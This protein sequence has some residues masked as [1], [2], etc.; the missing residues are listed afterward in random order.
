M[1]AS[2]DAALAGAAGALGADGDEWIA[3]IH[4]ED[5]I[6]S[7]VP[8]AEALLARDCAARWVRSLRVLPRWLRT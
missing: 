7:E 4:G 3:E 5:G 6:D 8:L 1:A 2:G